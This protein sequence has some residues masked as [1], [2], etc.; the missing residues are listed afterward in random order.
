MA[1]SNELYRKFNI[2]HA[3]GTPIA[4]GAE[5]FVLRV[6]KGA[7]DACHARVA[8]DYYAQGIA[9]D[10]PTLS[11]QILAGLDRLDQGE[12]FYEGR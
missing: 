6:D 2:T 1:K 9:E 7:D 11:T 12:P 4:N 8:V 3:D 5:Y 10:N